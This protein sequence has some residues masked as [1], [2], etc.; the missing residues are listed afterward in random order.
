MVVNGRTDASEGVTLAEFAD[1]MVEIDAQQAYNLDGGNSATL[2]FNGQ[3]YNDKPQAERS[4]TDIIYFASA[5]G[6]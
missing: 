6:E 5:I 3:V 2:A 4:V 1:I